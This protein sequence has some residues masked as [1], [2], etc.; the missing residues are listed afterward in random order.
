M[1]KLL[2]IIL[3]LFTL[4]ACKPDTK[5]ELVR[6]LNLRFTDEIR[7][8]TVEHATHYVLKINNEEIVIDTNHYLLTLEGTYTV[9]VKA[10]AEGYYDSVYSP[11]L[12]FDVD[13]TFEVPTNTTVDNLHSFQ[14]DLMSGATGY[15]LLVN[16]DELSQTTNS[17]DLSTYFPGVIQV[18]VKAIYPLGSSIYS[19]LIIYS[20]GAE[21][22]ETINYSY[23]INSLFDLDIL[24]SGTFVYIE[25]SEAEL[26]AA[27][28][29]FTAQRVT[30]K[31]TY[32]I[33][34][35]TGNHLF[36]ILTLD[37]FYIIDLN[38]LDTDKPYLIT[39]NQVFTDHSTDLTFTF[40]LF[41]GE[42]TG[43]S[44]NEVTTEDYTL[45]D[46]VLMIDKDYVAFM[47]SLDPERE[48][49]ILAYTLELEDN[50]VIGYLFIKVIE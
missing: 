3:L 31:N 34:L 49:L 38:I 16:G 44:G 11:A 12:T 35:S 18:Q 14:F 10:R 43:L 23:S 20:G 6:P 5:E 48:T 13:L 37:G 2:I 33:S 47:F 36:T 40:E 1:K 45:I 26:S 30:L 24:E 22:L 46:N 42:F 27:D 7:F 25:D 9:R 39:D 15:I 28:Y 41:G 32:L 21:T 19:E 17:L 29:I 8:D 50:I 4:Q